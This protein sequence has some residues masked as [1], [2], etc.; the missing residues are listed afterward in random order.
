MIQQLLGGLPAEGL[1]VEV[2]VVS[3]EDGLHLG[4]TCV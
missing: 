2:H 3:R 4:V 1:A